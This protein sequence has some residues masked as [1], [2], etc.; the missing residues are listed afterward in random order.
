MGLKALLTVW[1]K[2]MVESA[3]DRRALVSALLFGP[4]FGPVMFAILITLMLE[5][6]V[7][8]PDR[9]LDIAVAGSERAPNLVQFL[10]QNGVTIQKVELDY[11]AA[12]AAIRSGKRPV[13]VLIPPEYVQDFQA[14]KPAAVQVFS[15]QSDSRTGKYSTRVRMLLEYYNTKLAATRLTARGID[16]STIRPIAV[17]YVDVS[18]PAGRALLLLGMVTYFVLFS[19]LMGGLY[20][21]IDATAGERERGSLES[22]LTTPVPRQLLIY[23]KILAACC[24]MLISL[25]ITL[26]AFAISLT[27]VPLES[28]GMSANFNP[29]VALKFFVVAAPFVL[30]GAALM[31]VVASFTRTYKEAQSYLTTVLIV[32]TLP[33]V[34]ASLYSLRPTNALMAIPSLS[35]HLLMT[36]VLRD[37]PLSGIHLLISCTTT[38]A[39]GLGLAWIAGRLYRR[40]ALLG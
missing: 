13:V 20:L 28:L 2:E 16:P 10:E 24:F 19:M 7:T 14:G 17:D 35:Q 9:P 27:F 34:F 31:T 6:A 12:R 25:A 22:L 21:T 23:G 8:Q 1:A 3:R 26:V 33:I 38:L 39:L 18:T 5:R 29:L 40:E 15:D 37:E 32:P 11:A 4:L 30:P 36:G